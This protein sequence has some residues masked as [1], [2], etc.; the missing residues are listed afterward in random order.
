[1]QSHAARLGGAILVVAMVAMV[2]DYHG[3]Q[4]IVLPEP[5]TW[6][7]IQWWR[8]PSKQGSFM[9]TKDPLQ[10]KGTTGDLVIHAH[11]LVC[12]TR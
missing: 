2:A 7:V 4:I 12:W 9:P 5:C 8:G 3:G 10:T 6:M 1:M 11:G